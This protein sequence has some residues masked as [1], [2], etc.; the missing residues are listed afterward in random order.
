MSDAD[1]WFHLGMAL[2]DGEYY[3]LALAAFEPVIASKNATPL[4]RFAAST[5]KGHLLDLMG[6][7]EEAVAVYKEALKVDI[8]DQVIDKPT[9]GITISRKW[10]E[11]RLKTPFKRQ[12]DR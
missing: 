12:E 3:S 8:G 10:V 7:R 6:K 4:L 2:Y 11:E 9:A 5:W 1:A